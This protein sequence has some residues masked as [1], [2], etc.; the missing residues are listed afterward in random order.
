MRGRQWTAALSA[1]AKFNW[2]IVRRG[3]NSSFS[4]SCTAAVARPFASTPRSAADCACGVAPGGDDQKLATRTRFLGRQFD[5]LPCIEPASSNPSE[6]QEILSSSE[7]LF[8]ALDDNNGCLLLRNTGITCASNLKHLLLEQRQGH[9]HDTDQQETALSGCSKSGSGQA[10]GLLRPMDY[11][12]GTNNRETLADG[13]LDAGTEPSWIHLAEHSEM[14]YLDR[15][16]SIIAFCCLQPASISGGETT[17]VRSKSI[18]ARLPA[19]MLQKLRFHGI[20][21]VLY[22]GSDGVKSWQEAFFT[23]N[24]QDVERYASERGWHVEWMHA[25]AQHE[26]EL[27]NVRKE[28]DAVAGIA[29]VPDGVC[30]SFKQASYVWPCIL[31]LQGDSRPRRGT[32]V[33]EP[34]LFQTD[35]SGAWYHQWQPYEQLPFHRQPYSFRWGNGEDFSDDEKR[36]WGIAKEVH[37]NR[38]TCGAGV[39]GSSAC[40]SRAAGLNTI[41]FQVELDICA[42]QQGDLL[43]LDNLAVQHGRLPYLGNRA[44]GVVLANPVRRVNDNGQLREQARACVDD[45]TT[46]H[47]WVDALELG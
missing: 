27:S 21:H 25:S 23:T 47:E 9:L 26:S 24:Q 30:V 19:S 20:E 14:A 40:Y 2:P 29:A 34:V 28:T 4:A 45:A 6:V 13:V 8:N 38:S 15:F 16:P 44:M 10:S 5:D 39:A 11:V 33:R 1:V 46:N 43:I 37:M 41:F 3:S 17:V 22:Y 35:L 36:A 32:S 12:G 18:E 31:P 7:A 42:W